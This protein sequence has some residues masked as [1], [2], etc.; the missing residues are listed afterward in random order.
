MRVLAVAARR[1]VTFQPAVPQADSREKPS[2][3]AEPV[4]AHSPCSLIVPVVGRGATR[5][6][7]RGRGG[8]AG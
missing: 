3:N 8:T 1:T 7:A 4:C 5:G 6:G 2:V